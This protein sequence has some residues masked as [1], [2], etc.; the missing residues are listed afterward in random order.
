MFNY[1]LLIALIKKAQ[2]NRSLNQFA[3]ECG[4]DAGNLSRILN[5]KKVF[6]PKPDTLKK[7]A[8]M[9]YNNVTYEELMIA[10]G[11][12]D[13]SENFDVISNLDI[14]VSHEKDI[15][16]ILQALGKSLIENQGTLTISGTPAAP[17]TI[18]SLIDNLTF[19]TSQAKRFNE[20]MANRK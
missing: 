1:S 4:I 15:E 2:G 9:S 20:V 3:R 8:A 10:A 16:M 12:M 13:G 17:Q 18:Q 7:I 6:S 19:A 14:F 11:F 5:N